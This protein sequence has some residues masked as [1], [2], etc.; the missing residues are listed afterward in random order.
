MLR[1]SSKTLEASIFTAI[2]NWASDRSKDP[3]TQVGACVYDYASGGMYFGYNGFPKGIR[4]LDGRWERPSKYAY[5]IHAEVN[6]LLQALPALG[7]RIRECTMFVT[8]EPC[9]SCM[10]LIIQSGIRR[11]VFLT[12]RPD[13]VSV[14]LAAEAGVKVIQ[15]KP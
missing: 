12:S 7:H 3:N 13:P 1:Q 11:V 4:D 9:S 6:A 8:L 5:V 14:L 2:A 10:L 15:Y